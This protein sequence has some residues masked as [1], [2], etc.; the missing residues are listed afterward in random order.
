[1]RNFSR[2]RIFF[3]EEESSKLL[4]RKAFKL[5]ENFNEHPPEIIKKLL[6]KDNLI[7]RKAALRLGISLSTLYRW[8]DKY[9]IRIFAKR[10]SNEW[11]QRI[12]KSK[13]IIL[14]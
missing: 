12:I 7:P 6:L 8:M 2:P 13:Q 3:N 11:S 9:K 5:K 4:G 1:M 14:K 10:G